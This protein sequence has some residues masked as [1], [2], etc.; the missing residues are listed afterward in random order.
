MQNDR[1][2]I[3]LYHII[4]HNLETNKDRKKNKVYK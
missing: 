2:M 3:C 4:P 1:H